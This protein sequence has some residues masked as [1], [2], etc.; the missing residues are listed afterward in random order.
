M[1]IWSPKTVKDWRKD[2]RK[3]K[4]QFLSAL[5]HKAFPAL[6]FWLKTV[7]LFWSLPSVLNGCSSGGGWAD[8]LE[9]IP[10]PSCLWITESF[11]DWED[12]LLV[13]L[14][15]HPN[16]CFRA[17]LWHQGCWFSWVLAPTQ[18]HKFSHIWPL[19]TKHNQHYRQQARTDRPVK[20]L[21]LPQG[22]ADVTL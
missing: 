13:V 20:Q 18:H 6:F 2:E 1:Y 14:L 10:V 15:P 11:L 19:A 3:K 17:S 12:K 16:T 21:Y 4:N 8:Q 22:S 5:P 7:S 9:S